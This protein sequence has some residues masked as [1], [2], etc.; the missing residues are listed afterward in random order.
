MKLIRLAQL[1][2][3]IVSTCLAEQ[4]AAV[5]LSNSHSETKISPATEL[6]VERQIAVYATRHAENNMPMQSAFVVQLFADNPANFGPQRIASIYEKAYAERRNQLNADVW[7]E[8]KPRMGW[9]AAALL[10]LLVIVRDT[11]RD[12][13]VTRFRRFCRAVYA[14]IAGSRLFRFLAVRQY[15][16]ALSGNFRLLHIPFRPGRPLPMREV[17]VP[18]RLAGAIGIDGVDAAHVLS[19]SRRIMIVG[20]PGS[21]KSMLLKHIALSYA[22]GRYLRSAN[23]PIPVLLALHRL[24]G[25]DAPLF[26]HLVAE[27]ERNGFPEAD[28]LVRHH[29]KAGT[30]LLLFDGLDEVGTAERASVVQ[31]II[32][33]L[34]SYPS[35][36]FICTC[37]DAIYKNELAAAVEN[38]LEIVEFS[39][40]Q[41][42]RFLRTWA[43][44][45]PL[46]K[47]VEHLV[48]TL[49]DRPQILV[50]ARN[51]L[52]LTIIAYLYADTPFI[53]PHARAEF[54]AKATS[55]L[56][57]QWHTERN[58]YGATEKG[59]VLQSLALLLQGKAAHD[60]LDRRTIDC[61]AAIDEVGK[62]LRSLGR[63]FQDAK[64]LLQEIVERSGLLLEIDGGERY[65]FAHLSLQEFYAAKAMIGRNEA[66]W[67]R[68]LADPDS[69]REIVKLWC[70]MVPDSTSMVKALHAIDPLASFECLGEA[71][72]VDPDVAD[73]IIDGMKMRF[74]E[75][76]ESDPSDNA[77]AQAFGMVAA[78][79]RPRGRLIFDYLKALLNDQDMNKQK[80]ASNALSRT[81]LPAAAVE[82]ASC[83]GGQP[84]IRSA[85]VRMGD[86]AIPSLVDVV[87]RQPDAWAIGIQ[88]LGAIG[89]PEAAKELLT[90]VDEIGDDRAR[91]AAWQLAGLLE[92]PDVEEILSECPTRQEAS[93]YAWVAEPFEDAVGSQLST[94]LALIAEHVDKEPAPI[95]RPAQIDYRICMPLCVTRP[96]V[97]QLQQRIVWGIENQLREEITPELRNFLHQLGVLPLRNDVF[98]QLRRYSPEGRLTL[99]DVAERLGL[100][101]AFENLAGSPNLSMMASTIDRCVN[102]FFDDGHWKILFESVEAKFRY[103]LF[104]RLLR[105]PQP[106][107]DDWTKVLRPIEYEFRRGWHFRGLLL[108][109]AA[110]TGL[111]VRGL[112][113]RGMF[114]VTTPLWQSLLGAVTIFSCL[115]AWAWLL[116]FAFVKTT[117]RSHEQVEEFLRKGLLVSLALAAVVPGAVL[118]LK[119]WRKTH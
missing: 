64:P 61:R 92:N 55:L 63:E 32:D 8:W 53:L 69:W 26:Q 7:A 87:R 49:N 16:K 74:G 60:R 98:E 104:A 119:S 31:R 91:C 94:T 99:T 18:L 70:G 4:P 30:L 41:I 103:A 65:S 80:A 113:L 107:K 40:Y 89:T 93:R 58:K 57:D 95:M 101:T 59:A 117:T 5:P 25:S 56:L 17:Y 68:F 86:L 79:N 14:Q 36:R 33:F 21:G 109:L 42:R 39:D 52:L 51:P 10:L 45:M 12:W 11:V 108:M 100:H 28:E 62:V 37:R 3:L 34:H 114:L 112:V 29:L 115:L 76:N 81:N 111:A 19:K 82:M 105:K 83:Y 15:R 116:P 44:D 48:K 73:Q 102:D 90:I 96:S 43:A 66:L 85:L 2:V 13:L 20:R 118:K 9:I 88:D 77:I 54:Y 27:F 106:T 1:L 97:S 71:Q 23:E 35:C 110:V 47:S 78:D 67:G 50:L 6:S 72:L 46:G 22:E 24:N 75:P 84:W 38:T